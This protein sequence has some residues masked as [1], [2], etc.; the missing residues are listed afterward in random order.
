MN[1]L[2]TKKRLK[3]KTLDEITDVAAELA[4]GFPDPARFRIGIHEL[5]INAV[6]H[7]NLGLGFETKAALLQQGDWER[8]IKRRL[9]LPKFSGREVDIRLSENERVCCLTIEDQGDGFLWQKYF[10]RIAAGQKLSGRG[11]LLAKSCNFD[12]FVYNF[13]GNRVMCAVRY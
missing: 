6:E 12:R 4:H 9:G 2:A 7:G 13:R 1:S 3:L 8:E 5:L 11:L 10:E